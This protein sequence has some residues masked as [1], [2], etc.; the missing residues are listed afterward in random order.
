[1]PLIKGRNREEKIPLRI[2]LSESVLNEMIE[3]MKWAE[4]KYKD[5]FIEEACRHVLKSDKKW[6]SFKSEELAFVNNDLKDKK[7]TKK[8]LVN[9]MMAEDEGMSFGS[10]DLA[11]KI[12]TNNK[13]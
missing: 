4:I 9:K 3:Y 7:E 6:L 5:H 10:E 8:D 13:S 12:D 11:K 2:R 1:M